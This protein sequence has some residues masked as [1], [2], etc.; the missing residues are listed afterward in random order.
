MTAGGVPRAGYRRPRHDPSSTCQPDRHRRGRGGCR[1]DDRR[2]CVDGHRPGG[3]DDHAAAAGRRRRSCSTSACAPI[4]RRRRSDARLRSTS[5]AAVDRPRRSSRAIPPWRPRWE[6]RSPRGLKAF[7]V[8]KRSAATTRTAARRNSRSAWGS[9]GEGET[10][11]AES[12]WRLA[13]LAEP[14][15]LYAVRA[16]D[17]LHP[18]LPV[19]GLPTFVPSFASPAALKRL[20]PPEQY[21]FLRQRAEGGDTRDHLLFGAA[22]QRL[23][24]PA[25]ARREFERAAALSPND[26]DALTAVAVGHFAKDRPAQAFSRL[27]PLTRRFPRAATVRF[28]LGLLLV[29][30]GSVDD[31]KRQFRARTRGGARIDSGKAGGRVSAQAARVVGFTDMRVGFVYNVRGADAVGRR[32][33]TRSSTLRRRSRRSA[34]RS[35]LTA[36]TSSGWKPTARC[37][38]AL[39][40][41]RSTSSSTSPRAKAARPRGPGAR[42]ARAA[43]HPVYGQR[44]RHAR[45]LARQVPGEALVRAAGVATPR[46]F[47]LR[48]AT[49]RCR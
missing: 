34:T 43:G 15:S 2:H 27:G 23:G 31:A 29:W 6:R 38:A 30:M 48:P 14:D 44:R 36:T 3:G 28:H 24:R 18:E 45:H 21:A 12:S 11:E 33:R 9:S 13:K 17:F 16:G 10:R 22:L 19:P 8:F 20:S 35:R 40:A 41:P 26:P 42:A 25:S 4:R 1:R 39:V 5:A 7:S 49:S 37:P 32:T 46:G 47:V